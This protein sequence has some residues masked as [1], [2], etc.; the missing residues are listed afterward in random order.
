[1]SDLS[2]PNRVALSDKRQILSPS[3]YRN[4]IVQFLKNKI[5]FTLFFITMFIKEFIRYPQTRVRDGSDI[6]VAKRRDTAHSPT[7]LSEN[8][9]ISKN[10]LN[11]G[12]PKQKTLTLLRG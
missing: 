11:E 2:P 1:M 10:V 7:E 8:S 4:K 6:L 12:T 5:L 3:K 9:V